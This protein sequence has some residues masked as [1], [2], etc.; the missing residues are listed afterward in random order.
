MQCNADLTHNFSANLPTAVTWNLH[1][2]S[3]LP[4]LPCEPPRNWVAHFTCP[5]S[6]TDIT[7][8]LGPQARC[9]P[10]SELTTWALS[11]PARLARTLL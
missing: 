11:P 5:W 2:F 10:D 9:T 7:T 8:D 1:S 3:S 6:K 4:P